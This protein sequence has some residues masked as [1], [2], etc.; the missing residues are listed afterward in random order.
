MTFLA[1]CCRTLLAAWLCLAL[2]GCLPASG[3]HA[4]EEKEPY[5]Q[6]G[7]ALASSLDYQGAIAAFEKALEVNPHNSRAHFELGLLCQQDDR[8]LPAAI[9]HFE[10]FLLLRPA[11]DQADTVRQRILACKQDLARAI[12]IS[13][14]PVAQA[15]QRDLERASATNASLQ[16]EKQGLIAEKQ[17][18]QRQLQAWQAYYARYP[19]GALQPTNSV[20]SQE[21]VVREGVA[22]RQPEAASNR[23]AATGEGRRAAWGTA[24]GYTVQ[25]GDSLYLIAKKHGVKLDALV[26]ANPGVNPR[27]LKA[28]QP[29]S[30]PSP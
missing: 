10:R 14:A 12:S 30:I 28:G 23:A 5:F 3:D 16:A 26:A 25:S 7:K 29:I 13:L 27:R 21:A 11:S 18:L 6:R 4:D 9:Y 2:G 15:M 22:T 19:S 8:D 24:R 20:R 17:E 1:T